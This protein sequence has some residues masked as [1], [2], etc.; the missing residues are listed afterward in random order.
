MEKWNN[1]RYLRAAGLHIQTGCSCARSTR[2][3]DQVPRRACASGS[4]DVSIVPSPEQKA[5]QPAASL[6]PSCPPDA[7]EAPEGGTGQQS[8]TGRRNYSW[9]ELMKRVFLLDVLQC[10]NCGSRM[11]IVAAIEQPQVAAKILHCMELLSLLGISALTIF[12][13]FVR[14]R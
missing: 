4:L 14:I 10:E 2:A 5:G 12:Q 1:G 6:P 11:Q 3:P 13:D 9:A 8:S 7:T